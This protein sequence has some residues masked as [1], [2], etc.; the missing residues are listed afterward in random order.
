[1]GYLGYAYGQAGRS[2]EAERLADDVAPN[3]FSQ[4]L[5]YA[6]LGDKELAF[7]CLEKAYQ[8]HDFFLPWIKVDPWMDPLRSDARFKSFLRRVG[9]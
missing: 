2:D 3:A 9:L 7:R 1:M 8:K 6:G 5:I 4:A